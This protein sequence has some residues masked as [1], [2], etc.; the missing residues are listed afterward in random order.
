M[1]D[2]LKRQVNDIERAIDEDNNQLKIEFKVETWEEKYNLLISSAYVYGELPEINGYAATGITCSNVGSVA[3]YDAQ[4][5]M[6]N[7][8]I[9]STVDENGNVSSKLDNRNRFTITAYYPL[10]AY[11]SSNEKYV[12]LNIPLK[13]GYDGYNNPNDGYDNPYHSNIA[14]DTIDVI[15]QEHPRV[16][17]VYN[18]V[19]KYLYDRELRRHRYVVSKKLPINMYSN[20]ET[21]NE[22]KDIYKVEWNIYANERIILPRFQINLKIQIIIILVW[23]IMCHMQVYIFLVIMR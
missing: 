4:T 17:V 15:Y 20:T 14:E 12:S 18:F 21:E 8:T 6:F 22:E 23:T 10:E 19:G 1:T 11:T 16:D 5:K 9:S 7:V 2:T 3:T 13:A